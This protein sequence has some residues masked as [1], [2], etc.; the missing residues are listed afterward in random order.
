MAI[1][2]ARGPI[3]ITRIPFPFTRAWRWLA[4]LAALVGLCLP[5]PVPGGADG[6]LAQEEQLLDRIANERMIAFEQRLED[7]I[8]KELRRFLAPGQYVLSVRVIWDRSVIPPLGAPGL[9]PDKQ[10]LPGFP[11]FVRTPG[12]PAEE[13]TPPFTRLVVKILIDEILPDYYERFLRKTVPIV[14]RFVADRGDQLIV[15]KETF[16]ELQRAGLPPPLSE[17]ELMGR[18]PEALPPAAEPLPTG[19]PPTAPPVQEQLSPA[20]E[21]RVAYGEGR[22]EDALRAVRRGFQTARSNEERALFLAME[23]SVHYTMNN[24]EQAKAAWQRALTYN[25][26]DPEVLRVLEFLESR[27]RQ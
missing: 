1:L 21:A 18:L 20:Q 11:I 15:L 23:G 7:N 16:P 9:A 10:K 27:P 5:L 25:P 26:T 19:P 13:K 3:R 17:Q 2:L 14:A 22:Y 12:S 8:N 24:R 6:V 4:V